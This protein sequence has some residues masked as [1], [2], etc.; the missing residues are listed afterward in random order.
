M[1]LS[2]VAFL[3]GLVVAAAGVAFFIQRLVQPPVP[4]TVHV[5]SLAMGPYAALMFLLNGSLVALMSRRTGSWPARLLA[6]VVFALAI[7]HLAGMS[8]GRRWGLN[9]LAAFL[10]AITS[11]TAAGPQHASTAVAVTFIFA[12]LAGALLAWRRWIWASDA[13]A[14]SLAVVTGIIGGVAALGYVTGDP[15]LFGNDVRSMALTTALAFILLAAGLFAVAGTTEEIVRD[16]EDVTRFDTVLP[17]DK[18]F[19]ISAGSA[20]GVIIVMGLLSYHSTVKSIEAGRW[21]EQT[22]QV[23]VSLE[24]LLS[25]MKDAETGERGYLLTGREALLEPYYT[26]LGE[27]DRQLRDIVQLSKGQPERLARIA[28]IAPL[29]RTELLQLQQGLELKRAGHAEEAVQ[30]A[31]DA[32]QRM[33]DRV[34]REIAAMRR[35]LQ[36]ELAA[37]AV[38]RESNRRH[39][40]IVYTA[41]VIAVAFIVLGVHFLLERDLSG[42]RHAVAALR[43]HNETLRSFA[44]TVAHDLRAPLRGISGYA[45][46]LAHHH[47]AG[48]DERG[49]FCVHQIGSAAAN[50]DRLIEDTLDYAR[51]DAEVPR[52]AAVDL[53]LLVATLLR[54]RAPQIREYGADVSMHFAVTH[55]VTWERGLTQ[56]LGNLLDNAL[57]YSRPSRP[58]RIHIEATET[59]AAWQV[60]IQDNGIGF[61]M[62]YHDRIFGL[63]QRLDTAAGFEGT[64]AG[65]AI[66][67]KIVT[68]LG[69][70]VR[71]ASA[72]GAGATFTVELPKTAAGELV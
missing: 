67:K 22:Q 50:L 20:L 52:L 43:R 58:P 19:S 25:A 23:Q 5:V 6:T 61:D 51:L 12:S 32:G 29:I 46:E 59:A 13:L 26:A 66:V 35:E 56:V 14:G 21:I 62:K 33:M 44:H 36:D 39:A 41:A 64:G 30:L 42:R 11:G 1:K 9:E 47:A 34:R 24:S 53:P 3:I 45:R 4:G 38:L 63:F 7:V 37:R 65:L 17:L 55:P 28:G 71:A 31:A 69:G 60:S 2:R 10:A 18:K 8:V 49:R 16:P 48:L 27:I 54:E 68:R 15:L 70:A 40:F 72:P 57:K